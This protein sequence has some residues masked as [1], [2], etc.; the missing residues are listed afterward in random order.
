MT[1]IA[2]P[3]PTAVDLALIEECDSS[4]RVRRLIELAVVRHACR[5]IV[6]LMGYSISVDDGG[7]EPVTQIKDI[8]AIVT[9]AFAVDGCRLYV[10]EPAT[11]KS[12]YGWIYLVFG[13]DGWDVISDH[14]VN[15]EELLKPTMEYAEQLSAWC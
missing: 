9:A 4:V 6:L 7:D 13:N 8:D 10:H 15:L 2:L 1:L 5:R 12:P 3:I 11:N 14:S